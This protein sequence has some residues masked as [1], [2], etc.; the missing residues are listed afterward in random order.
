[1]IAE[2][3]LLV[4]DDPV[5]RASLQEYLDANGYAVETAGT[6]EAA[7]AAV[8]RREFPVV[9]TDLRLPGEL[10]GLDLALAIR[11][12]FPDTLCILITGYATLDTSIRALKQGFYDLLQKPFRMDEIGA[13]LDRALDHA[14]LLRK[15]AAYRSELETRIYARSR[16]LREVQAEALELCAWT[17]NAHRSPGD[18]EAVA[19]YLARIQQRWVPDGLACYRTL[20]D[21]RL[22]CLSKRGIRPLPEQL[23][24]LPDEVPGLGYREEHGIAL[25]FAGWLYLGFAGRSAFAASDSAFQL[26]AAHLELALRLRYRS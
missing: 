5:V 23:A 17:S 6:V 1:M 4:D 16:E 11:Q 9:L 14:R 19:P 15:L 10:T 25:G 18:A 8:A 2:P 22:A 13:V 21:G 7:L 20:P 24:S 3:I 12:R 26:V